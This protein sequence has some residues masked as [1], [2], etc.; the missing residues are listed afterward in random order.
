VSA[1]RRPATVAA[2]AVAVFALAWPLSARDASSAPSADAQEA[3]RLTRRSR[4]ATAHHDF[5]GTATVTWTGNHGRQQA[6]VQV[7]DVDGAVEIV[8]ADGGKVI[9]EGRRTYLRDQLG[10][11]VVLVEPVAGDLPAPTAHWDLSVGAPRTVAGRPTTTVVAS[12]RDGTPAQR[13]FVDDATGLLLGRQVLGPAGQV[14]RS[15]QF[16]NVDIGDARARVVAPS[17]V[18]SATAKALASVP[19][20]YRAPSSLDDYRLVT[21]SRHPDGVLLFYSD[22]VFTASVFEQLGDLDWGA[23]PG[24]GTDSQLAGTRTRTYHDPSG[25]VV[26]WTRDGIVYTCV[27]DAPSDVFDGMV[28][29]LANG[30]RSTAQ[31]VVDFVLGPFGW[32]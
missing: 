21:R 16:V 13:L 5:S 30:D 1:I 7:H 8:A 31:S 3:A 18:H 2:C 24:G 10:W 32:S 17:G 29:R 15:V 11:T 28:E 12:R 25:D 20:G 6:Q 23:L 26:V 9:D 19:D 14:Q 22:G 4:D 27:S